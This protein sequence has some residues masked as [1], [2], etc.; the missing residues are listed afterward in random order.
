M[1]CYARISTLL[2]AALTAT[3]CSGTA[4]P[5]PVFVGHVVSHLDRDGGE[6]AARG[7][8]LAVMEANKDPDKGAGRTVK[9]IHTDT[10]GKLEAFEAEGVR[11]VAVNRA[12]ALL[13][14]T[15]VEEVE[16]LELARV[17]VVAPCGA[18]PPSGG[19]L[20]FCTGLA[21]TRRG[22]V[23]ARF[24]ADELKAVSAAVVVDERRDEYVR[25]AEAFARAFPAALAKKQPKA[26]SA[27][28]PLVRF[29]AEADFMEVAQRLR[30]DRP[31]LLLF[32][33][34]PA[35]LRRLREEL[36]DA[37][38]PLLFGGDEGSLRALREQGEA[39][40]RLY[41][42][43]A[44]AADADV[45]RTQEFV[46]QFKAT[47]ETEPDVHAALAYDDARLL[48]EAMR[49]AQDNLT[50]AHLAEELVKVKDFPGVTG[51]LSFG[52]DRQLRRAAFVVRLQNGRATAVK[53]YGP[54]E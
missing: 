40:T 1:S 29:G 6:S 34:A 11:L 27:T 4:A 39:V 45:P 30:K 38:P 50:G 21:P 16:R 32:A 49:R 36:G 54:E 12:V 52:D 22:T 35:D 44:F 47:F 15:T 20:V 53:R 46:K 8:R 3:G 9:V 42:V 5:P 24:A 14:G 23:L 48:F 13:G 28:V 17:P 41:L 7:I 2:A 18:L 26:P 10:L 33:G 25:L 51:L 37:V 19:D 43:T 31:A